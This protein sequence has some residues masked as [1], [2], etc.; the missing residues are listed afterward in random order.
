M[1]CD[2][3]A[4]S[5]RL[6][7]QVAFLDEHPDVGL[8]SSFVTVMTEDGEHIGIVKGPATHEEILK[9]LKRG[10]MCVVHPSCFARR[11]SM[12]QVLYRDKFPCAVDYDLML[13]Y[14]DKYKMGLIPESLVLYRLNRKSVTIVFRKVQK[15][16]LGAA[17]RFA[18]EREAKGSDSY[19]R[20]NWPDF[21]GSKP[22]PRKVLSEYQLFIGK[23]FGAFGNVRRARAYFAKS[24][25]ANP[26]RLRPYLLLLL[27]LLGKK[28]Y[29]LMQRKFGTTDFYQ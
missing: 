26:L 16:C 27:A 6:E 14:V 20:F 24:I 3:I 29:G 25:L 1:D 10:G 7:K 5:D 19:E 9:C 2:D 28:V 18:D 17:K 15:Y 11:D 13:R 23:M 8:V 21:S 4:R 22:N 12:Q